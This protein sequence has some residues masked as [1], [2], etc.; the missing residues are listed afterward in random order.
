MAKTKAKR[1]PP[2]PPP[3]DNPEFVGA[4]LDN[5]WD[6]QPRLAYAD[7]LME[8]GQ[9]T[10]GSFIAGQIRGAGSIALDLIRQQAG[11]SRS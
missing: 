6:D 9:M 11:G 2:L 8:N 3:T 5:P 1:K 7:W 10:R 4:I